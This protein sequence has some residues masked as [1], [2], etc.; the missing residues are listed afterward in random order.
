MRVRHALRD[1]VDNRRTRHQ[2]RAEI[3]VDRM[4]QPQPVLLEQRAIEAEQLADFLDALLG[5]VV[6]GQRHRGIA[7]HELQQREHH[8]RRKH[9][10]R[11][12]LHEPPPDQRVEGHEDP[13]SMILILRSAAVAARLEG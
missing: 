10:D 8:E 4:P 11:D 6:A 9:D 12:E 1:E 7:G 5:G 13:W 2:G 3:A